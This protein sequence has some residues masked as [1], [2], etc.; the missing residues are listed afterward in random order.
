MRFLFH[1]PEVNGTSVDMLDPGDVAEVAKAAEAA[2]FGGFSFT[3]HPAPGAR[4]LDSGGHQS[5]DPF[6]AL[7]YVAGVTSRIRLLTYLSPAPYR[8]P[9]LLA[10][11]AATVDRLSA[12][13]FILGIGTGYLAGEFRALGV[14]IEERNRLFDEAL[15]VLPMHWSGEPFSYKGLHFE[16]KNVIARPTPVQNPIP[17]WIGGNSKLARDRVARRADGWMPML[18]PP[19]VHQTVRSPALDGLAGVVKL[20]AQIRAEAAARGASIDL[21]Y[22]YQDSSALVGPDAEAS[23]HKDAFAELEDAGVTWVML[24]ARGTS[25]AEQT[26]A[27]L[28]SFGEL[29]PSAS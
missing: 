25:S 3:E 21:V 1:Y 29:Y 4:W 26:L 5:L 12:G 15:D 20:A 2:G 10:K 19:E 27:F 6:V 7:A 14:D 17:I 8:N 23:R 16:A 11:A 24:S 28:A 13:R 22:P 9:L 18:L